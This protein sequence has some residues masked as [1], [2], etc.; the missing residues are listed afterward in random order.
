MKMTNDT[1]DQPIPDRDDMADD[2]NLSPQEIAW[3]LL[4]VDAAALDLA[5]LKLE[6]IQKRHAIRNDN[7][8]E[9][10]SQEHAR[11]HELTLRS[12]DRV[13]ASLIELLE[14]IRLKYPRSANAG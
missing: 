14:A 13:E 6:Q 11:V 5:S 3:S 9:G 7:P 1:T 2:E 4:Q 12:V 10:E 8:T